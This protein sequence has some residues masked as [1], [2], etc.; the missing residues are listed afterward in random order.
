MRWFLLLLSIAWLLGPDSA[1]NCH[2]AEP[3]RDLPAILEK[4]LISEEVTKPR[5]VLTVDDLLKQVADVV[6]KGGPPEEWLRRQKAKAEMLARSRQPKVVGVW[7]KPLPDY[8][9]GEIKGVLTDDSTGGP[10][11]DARVFLEGTEV[12]C[13]TNNRGEY[14]IPYVPVGDCSLRFVHPQYQQVM[15]TD[16][17]IVQDSTTE[18]SHELTRLGGCGHHDIRIKHTIMLSPEETYKRKLE[19]GRWTD[20]VRAN[21]GEAVEYRPF[22]TLKFGSIQGVVTDQETGLPIRGALTSLIGAQ[23][24][25]ETNFDGEYAVYS[26]EG[27]FK[28]RVTHPDYD[29]RE[30]NHIEIENGETTHLS[31]EL[32]RKVTRRTNPEGGR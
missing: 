8:P 32:K 31:L 25:G 19:K 21:K 26:L 10:I 2:S 5:P 11:V 17:P 18:Y 6:Y 30:V 27:V 16:L 4:H 28:L 7:D 29:T 3:T 14:E 13:I 24:N 15:V 23:S 9:V 12:Y 1:S 22:H 20:S